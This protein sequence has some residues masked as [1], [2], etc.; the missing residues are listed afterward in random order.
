MAS[1]GASA[2]DRPA[3]RSHAD[4]AAHAQPDESARADKS[5]P[6]LFVPVLSAALPAD[7]NVSQLT[8]AFEAELR[9]VGVDVLAN[10]DAARNFETRHS[11][12][13]VRL[14]SD[15]MS[16]LLRNVGQAARHLALGELPQAQQAMEGVYALS[17]PARDYLNREA[18]RA[19]KIFDT[20]LMTAYLWE[21]D[22]QSAQALRQMLEC[23]RSFPGFR[24]EGRAYPPELRE[25]FEQAKAQ[26]NQGPSTTLFVTNKQGNSCGVRLNGIELGKSPMSFSDVR[27]GITRVQLECESGA[28][29]RIHAVELKA[30]ENKLTIDPVFDAAVH[31]NGALWLSYSQESERNKHADVD[32]ETI[33]QALGASRPVELVVDGGSYPRVH[34]RVLANGSRE[35]ATLSYS[36][37]GYNHDAVVAA[38]KALRNAKRPQPMAALD[39]DDSEAN[40]GPVEL[41]EDDEP[42]PPPPPAAAPPASV[43]DQRLV[44]GLILAT[45]GVGGLAT[46][47]VLYALRQNVRRTPWADSDAIPTSEL[48][49]YN[50]NAVLTVSVAGAGALALSAAD[51]F[52]L[53]NDASVPALA[54]VAGG[55]GA[56]VGLT[57]LA[58][59]AFGHR[60]PR[61]IAD[62]DSPRACQSFTADATFGPIVALHALPLIAVPI[63]YLL[64]SAFR[65]TGVEVSLSVGPLQANA[66]SP[67]L[68]IQG[69]F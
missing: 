57:G 60:C 41:D 56:A 53:P 59:G 67:G 43:D 12:E 4:R 65:P 44:P 48:R 40:A 30:G 54:W 34:M 58:F 26:L 5:E 52:W 45:V 31:S 50:L 63:S 27:S 20:C 25:V 32:T 68:W 38:I 29:G 3:R 28:A 8:A 35:I 7:V 55:V 66:S 49:S 1:P 47:W 10:T 9:N 11:S 39:N 21:R 6:F 17:G 16:R 15:E 69:V 51:Y 19:R 36:A 22:H 18:A 64:R 37:E 24:P 46:G 62:V 33:R 14:D 13:P 61:L 42:P 2:Q 23:S